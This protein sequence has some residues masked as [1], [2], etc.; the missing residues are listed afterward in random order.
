MME[1]VM[2]IILK[3]PKPRAKQV[4]DILMTKRCERHQDMRRP[5][6]SEVKQQTQRAIREFI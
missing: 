1:N 6:R 4:N 5:S 2:K 3:T